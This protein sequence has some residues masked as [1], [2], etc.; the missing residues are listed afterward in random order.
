VVLNYIDWLSHS[1]YTLITSTQ[2]FWVFF[3]GGI[4][5]WTQSLV[6]RSRCSITWATLPTQV[7]KIFFKSHSTCRL[8]LLKPSLIITYH[9]R[10]HAETTNLVIIK[11]NSLQPTCLSKESDIKFIYILLINN[12]SFAQESKVHLTHP[13]LLS[14]L[15]LPHPVILKTLSVS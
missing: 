7:F 8:W 2:V 1:I 15:P 10:W 6:L 12:I 11:L 13:L 9:F 5:I 14:L 3:G 4:G